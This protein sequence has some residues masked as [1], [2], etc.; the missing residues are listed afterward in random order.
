MQTCSF[1]RHL[2]FSVNNSAKLQLLHED[3][4]FLYTSLYVAI[5]LF[6]QLSELWQ[7]GVKENIVKASKRQQD[8]SNPDSLD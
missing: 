8:D 3:C 2:D 6:M 1:R 7:R 5:C 4:L